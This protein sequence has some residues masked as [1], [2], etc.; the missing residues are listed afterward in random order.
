MLDFLR[1]PV[2]IFLSLIIAILLIFGLVAWTPSTGGVSLDRLSL[3]SDT[4]ALLSSMTAA[5]KNS[6]FW[7]TLLL[8]YAFPLTYGAFFA[9]LALRLPGRVGVVLAIPAFLVFGADV[10]ENTVQ[11]LALKGVDGLLFT[12]EWLTPAKFFL[13]DVAAAIALASALWFGL[14]RA[15]DKFRSQPTAG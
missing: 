11:L 15:Y 14:N 8:D 6:H 10:I 7:M 2:V 13:F 5:Q 12:K 9:G 3:V 1:R 4:T